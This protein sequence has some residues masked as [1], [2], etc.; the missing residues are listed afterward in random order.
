M[1]MVAIRWWCSNTRGPNFERLNDDAR[2]R[3]PDVVGGCCQQLVGVL[4]KG[5]NQDLFRP[6][7]INITSLASRT[8]LIYLDPY[9]SRIRT[10]YRLSRLCLIE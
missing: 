10:Y 8:R 9:H 6:L 3:C 2:P 4:Y 1:V 7:L 5:A